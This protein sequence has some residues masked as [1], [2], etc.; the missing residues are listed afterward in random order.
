MTKSALLIATAL[1]IVVTATGARAADPAA[2]RTRIDAQLDR[3][4]PDLDA[5]Y[6]DLHAHPEL[7]FQETRT[8]GL[9]AARMRKLGF[10]VTEHLA[11]TGLVAILRNGPG[12]L[13]M[14][15]T[16]LDG[17][18]VEEKTGL[19][20]ASHDQQQRDGKPVFT[21]HACG[22]DTHMA[23]W[24]GTAEALIALKSQWHGTL[25]FVA[26]PAEESGGG[27]R[28]MIDEGLF[29]RFG[30]PDYAFGVHV[31]PYAAGTVLVKQGPTTAAFDS[32]RILFHGVGAHGSMPDK[33]IDPIVE[34]AHFVTDVQTVISRQKDP[35]AFGV[36]TVGA[37]NAGIAGNV[38]PDQADLRVTTRSYSESVRKL[39]FDGVATT[40]KAAAMMAHAPA[41]DIVLESGS[42]TVINDEALAARTA[43]VL[44]AALG[45]DRVTL[46]PTATPGI[47]GSEDFSE[48]INAGVP[49]AVWFMIGGHDPKMLAD[50][51]AA[52]KAVP[53]NH[54]PFFAPLP[55]PTI[56]TG[57]EVLTL[58]VLTVAGE[59]P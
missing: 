35:Q 52:G 46:Q 6:R 25:M 36:V 16:E 10:T 57:V 54:S 27:A 12:P 4:Y 42:P 45:A 47:T 17:L 13:V 28:Q 59:A 8:A 34:A 20:Y 38:I 21:D 48:F 40:A 11:K 37:F 19:A 5:L 49:H 43:A 53:T 7:G 55:G 18:P 2:A 24:I 33:S 26:Q 50:Y 1:A 31:L 23:A 44:T 14:V 39:L 9:L 15:R 29:K 32:L 51:Q 30:K 22:H 3:D 41:P 56:R 58:A